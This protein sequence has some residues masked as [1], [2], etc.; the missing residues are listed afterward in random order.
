[1]VD[2][3]LWP[4][5]STR[6]VKGEIKMDLRILCLFIFFSCFLAFIIPF[7]IGLRLSGEEKLCVDPKTGECKWIPIKKGDK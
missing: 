2:I 4:R 6:N 5:E 3:S 1:M 7:F